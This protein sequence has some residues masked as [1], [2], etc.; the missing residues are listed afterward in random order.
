MYWYA[1]HSHRHVPKNRHL[2]VAFTAPGLHSQRPGS[3]DRR[4]PPSC[5]KTRENNKA[6]PAPLPA[7]PLAAPLAALPA[8]LP[9]A[10]PTALPA[11]LPAPRTAARRRSHRRSQRCSRHCPCHCP[12]RCPQ[13][14]PPRCPRCCPQRHPRATAHL[15]VRSNASGSARGW[16]RGA[17]ALLRTRAVRT[18]AL[19]LVAASRRRCRRAAA[20]RDAAAACTQATGLREGGSQYVATPCDAGTGKVGERAAA[21]TVAHVTH[22]T[23]ATHA[24]H[25]AHATYLCGSLR[26]PAH[27]RRLCRRLHHPLTAPAASARPPLT[28]ATQPL[29]AAVATPSAPTAGCRRG[30]AATALLASPQPLPSP[31][32]RN[33]EVRSRSR[34]STWAR[35]HRSL[36]A[37]ARVG[38]RL[39]GARIECRRRSWRRIETPGPTNMRREGERGSPPARKQVLLAHLLQIQPPAARDRESVCWT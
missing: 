12:Q 25:T 37:L 27:F 15:K 19:P 13:R 31:P 7:A 2:R 29:T 20:R 3:V 8:P 35:G 24:T 36:R 32:P 21:P 6:L 28:P 11:A 39:T 22:A 4:A 5:F 23:H 18:P 30:S 16:Q 9:T 38:Q 34:V 26:A 1:W 17:G 10:L 33:L 14:C